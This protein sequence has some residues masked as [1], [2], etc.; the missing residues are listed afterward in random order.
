MKLDYRIILVVLAFVLIVGI[1][2]WPDSD[3]KEAS[4]S[5]NLADMATSTKVKNAFSEVYGVQRLK[6]INKKPS[7]YI[8]EAFLVSTINSVKNIRASQLMFAPMNVTPFAKLKQDGINALYKMTSIVQFSLFS[9]TWKG[10]NGE[11]L[12]TYLTKYM[13]DA[14]MKEL[15]KHIKRLKDI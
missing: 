5:A 15:Y 4:D 13:T 12:Q 9:F 3:E 8:K 1:L 11:P 14:E 6:K 7:E 10:E 2:L